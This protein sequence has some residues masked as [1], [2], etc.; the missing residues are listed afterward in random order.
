MKTEWR[1][2]GA[3]RKGPK[4]LDGERNLG[5]LCQTKGRREQV[6][7]QGSLQVWG[8]WLSE[9]LSDSLSLK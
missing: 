8:M 9:W 1:E 7:M 2:K 3:E 4:N 5:F 6:G